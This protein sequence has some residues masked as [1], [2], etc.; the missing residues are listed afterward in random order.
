VAEFGLA[1]TTLR[2]AKNWQDFTQGQFEGLN[3][4]GIFI[5]GGSVLSCLDPDYPNV[6]K[7]NDVD[8]F[9]YATDEH[10]AREQ[11][12]HI[13][14]TVQRNTNGKGDIIRTKN[15]ITIINSYPYRHIQIIMRLY[16]SPAEVLMGF[17][18]DSCTV[19]FGT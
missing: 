17:D 9:L 5:A 7:G 14:D 4:E 13:F 8:M 3:W 18:I 15:A 1:I 11:L 12:R 2:W 6:H 10:R 16:K 19:G